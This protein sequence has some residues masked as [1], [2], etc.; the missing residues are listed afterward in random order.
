M[1]REEGCFITL[2]GVGLFTVKCGNC[3]SEQ[4]FPEQLLLLRQVR[5][6]FYSGLTNRCLY[7]EKCMDYIG[8]GLEIGA[9]M[10]RGMFGTRKS[11]F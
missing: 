4:L 1:R 5:S 7:Y 9:S 11:G 10:S 3:K 6:V 2:V 8:D